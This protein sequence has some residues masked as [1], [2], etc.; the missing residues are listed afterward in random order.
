MTKVFDIFR[1][2]SP[3]VAHAVSNTMVGFILTKIS[4]GPQP[5]QLTRVIALSK[6]SLFRAV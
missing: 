6:V 4:C 3:A 5:L 2:H 1:E